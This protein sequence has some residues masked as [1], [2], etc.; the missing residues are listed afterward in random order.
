MR[1]NGQTDYSLRIMMLLAAKRGESVTIQEISTRLGLSQAHLMRICAKLASSGFVTSTRGR[2]GGL[3]LGRPPGQIS[4]TDLVR[5]IEPDFALVQCFDESK[6]GCSIER[7]C[8]LKGVLASALEAF[9][10]ELGKASLA[11]LTEA[12]HR[13]LVKVFHFGESSEADGFSR[14]R[15]TPE[16]R[17]YRETN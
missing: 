5:A 3:T 10:A 6:A 17:S 2:T 4:L 1:L 14:P 8:R 16:S 11:D 9:F 15:R 7:T 13:D 12:N